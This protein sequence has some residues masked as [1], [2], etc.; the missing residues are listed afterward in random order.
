MTLKD[1]QKDTLKVLKAFFSALDTKTPEEAYKEI[2]ESSLDMMK[3]L[4]GQRGYARTSLDTP[5]VAIKVPTGGG[6]TII[7]AH[8]VKLIAECQDREYPFVIWFAPTDTIRR[9]TGDARKNPKQLYR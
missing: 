9:Q 1:Y 8:A 6:K 5:T 7:A 4:G 3:R 2:T